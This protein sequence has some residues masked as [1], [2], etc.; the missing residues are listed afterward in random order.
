MPK[1]HSASDVADIYRLAASSKGV[2]VNPALTEPFGLTLLEAAASGLPLVATEIGGPVEII[3]NCKNG[4]LVDPLDEASITKALLQILEDEEL[5]TTLSNNGK[6][7]VAR[8]YTWDA[9]AKLYLESVTGI[10]YS[11][12][13]AAQSVSLDRAKTSEICTRTIKGNPGNALPSNADALSIIM[14]PN[15]RQ[16]Q[17]TLEKTLAFRVQP[18]A[19]GDHLKERHIYDYTSRWKMPVDNTFTNGQAQNNTDCLRRSN[20]ITSVNSENCH[21]QTRL[22][23]PEGLSFPK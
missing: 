9:H 18:Q 10:I 23:G 21:E 19:F 1:H 14:Q 7:N 13:I 11:S 22:A 8:F 3:G 4:L 6:T 2:F 12:Q 17:P 15:K 5:W 20:A 16:N